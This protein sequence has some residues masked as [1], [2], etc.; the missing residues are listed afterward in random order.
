[1]QSIKSKEQFEW[2]R[3]KTYLTII[4]ERY[5]FEMLYRKVYY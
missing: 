2:V 3:V 4:N 1:M 5:A